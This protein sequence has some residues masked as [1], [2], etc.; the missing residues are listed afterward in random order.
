M[1]TALADVLYRREANIAYNREARGRTGGGTLS[2]VFPSAGKRRNIVLVNVHGPASEAEGY[3]RYL[4]HVVRT[5]ADLHAPGSLL[6]CANLALNRRAADDEND[7]V[8][9]LFFAALQGG[10]LTY[11]S[12]GHEL[13]LLVH[14]NGRHRQLPPTGK[15]LGIKVAQ[16]YRQSA[17]P[18][19]PGDWLFL[20]SEGIVRARDAAG[21]IFGGSGFAGSARSAIA[22]GADDPA[23]CILAA[24]RAH[25]GDGSL[26]DA[27]ILCL[28]FS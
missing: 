19:A 23:A 21:T 9:G 2:D 24:A 11:A 8:A 25:A 16:H 6:E 17:F 22:A 20:A 18:V 28:R 12:G 10:S 27:A 7:C 26:E 1:L 4:R 14:K 13:A 15:T 3:A 5:L